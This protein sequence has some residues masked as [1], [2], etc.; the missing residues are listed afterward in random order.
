MKNASKLTLAA[1]AIAAF[2]FASCDS[3]PAETV[4]SATEETVNEADNA[5]D[6]ATTETDTITVQDQ[7]VQDGLG[8]KADTAKT[9]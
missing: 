8:D 4:E 5:M 6:E 3:K 1:F 2:S 7:P 9:R